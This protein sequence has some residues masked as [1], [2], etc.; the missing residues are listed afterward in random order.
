[1]RFSYK[2]ALLVLSPL[3][4]T[5]AYK[6]PNP[7]VDELDHQLF[8]Q[9][10]YN[11][12]D[13][14][15]QFIPTCKFF[16]SETSGRSNAAEAFHDIAT[17]DTA[18]GAGG[19]DASIAVESGRD[20]NRGQA[21][22]TTM[23]L[24]IHFVTP[25]VSLSDLLALAAVNSVEVCGGPTIPFRSGRIDNFTPSPP[26]VPEPHQD[27]QTH[28]DMFRRMGFTKEEM[29]GLVACGHSIGGVHHTAFPE[30]VPP[31]T[32]P[33]TNEEG[34]QHFDS[35]FDVY[36]NKVA[37]DF[38]AG[39]P[40]NALAFGS[41]ET[42]R[43]D[44]R[45]FTSDGNRTI[46]NFAGDNDAFRSTCATLLEKMVNTVPSAVTLSDVIQPIPVKPKIYLGLTPE[47]RMQ[48]TGEVR[49]FG[50]QENLQRTVL[51]KWHDR[52]SGCTDGST[53]CSSIT[54]HSARQVTTLYQGTQ[55]RWYSFNTTL[56]DLAGISEFW[57]EVDEHDG[58]GPKQM[59]S[60][61]GKAFPVDDRF[62]VVPSKSCQTMQFLDGGSVERVNITLAVRADVN[63]TRVNARISRVDIEESTMLT[64]IR[65]NEEVEATLFSNS[66]SSN[67]QL[68]RASWEVRLSFFK[69]WFL[70]AVLMR[71]IGEEII[72]PGWKLADLRPPVGCT[73]Q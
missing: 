6:W 31:P 41:N 17:H 64:Y 42:T 22:N 37:T 26:G 48:V 54:T 2:L 18:A 9:K 44:F 4:F 45:I 49:F 12:N 32:D 47:G 16:I 27:L 63:P 62:F 53:Q 21:I 65:T 29:I 14:I 35:T 51:F 46:S 25:Q 5:F 3:S 59:Y 60:E 43:S 23:Q 57:F 11:N 10:G 20:E 36:D 56:D 66:T 73:S 28:S 55:S 69:T 61:T 13:T 67:Y 38:M 70:D 52:R 24:L 72:D 15:N 58:T 40:H 50:M 8:D 1:M 33:R 39:N 34:V 71:E 30:I 7:L 68:Y 19:L